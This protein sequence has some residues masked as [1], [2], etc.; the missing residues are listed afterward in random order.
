MKKSQ[1]ILLVLATLTLA[2]QATLAQ[3][4]QTSTPPASEADKEAIYTS[5]LE[6]RVS[7]IVKGLN[8]TNTATADKVT[9][10][11]IS[12]YRV[13]RARDL[14]INARLTGAGKEVNYANRADD[15]QAESKVLHAQFVAKLSALLTPEQVDFV[16]D[17][18]TYNKVKVT[19][20]AYCSIIPGLKDADKAKILESL[21]AA[22]EEAIDGGNA[23]EKSAIFQKY[24]DRIN[25]DLN[26]SG[27]DVAKAYKEWEA[28][29]QASAKPAD[30]QK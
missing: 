19:Y 13:M 8:L 7:D 5:A 11:L 25:A 4:S 15:L 1:S 10:L 26:A 12:H 16:K 6:S 2:A 29:Q 14:V 28:K 3:E 20:D 30:A 22:R 17:K 21:K 23:P 18:M 24:K 9:D 27:Y